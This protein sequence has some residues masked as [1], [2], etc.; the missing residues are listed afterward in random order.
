MRER[1]C[2]CVLHVTAAS[3]M[4]RPLAGNF[5]CM[6]QDFFVSYNFFQTSNIL[7]VLFWG[8]YSGTPKGKFFSY[9]L[10]I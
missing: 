7:N 1:M 6:I 3:S 4:N 9:N 5:S 2:L 8:A 10:Q